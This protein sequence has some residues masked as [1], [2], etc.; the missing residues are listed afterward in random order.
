MFTLIILFLFLSSLASCSDQNIS[1]DVANDLN[2]SVVN[3]NGVQLLDSVYLEDQIDIYYLTE[4]G[5]EKVNLNDAPN[6]FDAKYPENF[7]F[8]YYDNDPL[9]LLFL[10][11]SNSQT[12]TFIDW[13]DGDWDT[14][15]SEIRGY[16]IIESF[17]NGVR[18]GSI[19]SIGPFI[20]VVK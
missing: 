5:P 1:T 12:T 7:T 10:D 13:G 14:I 17:Y 3:S 8:R 6:V 4:K 9:M 2:I 19:D 15:T 11:Y 18:V 20:E 16:T